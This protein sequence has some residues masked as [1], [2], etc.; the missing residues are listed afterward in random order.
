MLETCIEFI[1]SSLHYCDCYLCF[2]FTIDPS[3]SISAV[4]SQLIDSSIYC[5]GLSAFQS[6]LS[7]QGSSFIATRT[8]LLF[9]HIYLITFKS[10]SYVC[11]Y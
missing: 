8:L 5:Y 3:F 9:S 7:D 1:D 11:T 6:M 2:T 10:V 4:I